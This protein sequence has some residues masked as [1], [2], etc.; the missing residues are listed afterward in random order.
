MNLGGYNYTNFQNVRVKGNNSG[1]PGSVRFQSGSA[2]EQT[3]VANADYTDADK[4]VTLPAKTGTVGVTGTFS[5]SLPSAL[6]N[7]NLYST[8]VTVTGIRAEDGLVVS[9]IGETGTYTYGTQGTRYIVVGAKPS[10]G[11][12]VLTF[13]NLGQGTGYI[14]GLTFGYTAVR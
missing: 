5:V 4:T 6:G 13:Q 10:N 2:Y 12:I 1:G 8:A 11:S 7:A 9:P 3:L 14:E